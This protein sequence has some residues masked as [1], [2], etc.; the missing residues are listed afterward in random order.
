MKKTGLI[1]FSI[2]FFIAVIG[3]FTPCLTDLKAQTGY[4]LIDTAKLVAY[5]DFLG[6]F[7]DS[8]GNNVAA[9][10]NEAEIGADRYCHPQNE[11]H[12]A[13]TDNYL[14]VEDH[15]SLDFTDSSIYLL[16]HFAGGLKV[17]EVDPF[18]PIC[19]LPN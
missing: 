17:E 11:V 15:T 1:T 18:H 12:L 7:R 9:V 5:Y 16:G 4:P 13:S 8:T 2:T 19:L 6:S 10:P 3:F 14:R